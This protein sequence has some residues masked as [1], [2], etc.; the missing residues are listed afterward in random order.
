MG[1]PKEDNEES[2]EPGEEKFR[3][4]LKHALKRLLQPD[5]QLRERSES[6]PQNLWRSIAHI[7]PLDILEGVLVL[8]P[9]QCE[10]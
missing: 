1:E 7:D 9:V 10:C 3:I 8:P 6:D 2:T 5:R 4:S